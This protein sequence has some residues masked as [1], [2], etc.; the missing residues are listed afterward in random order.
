MRLSRR[1][2][3]IASFVKSDMVLGD[4]GSDHGFLPYDLLRR[5]AISRAYACDNKEGPYQNLRRTF[6][7]TDL[8]I[9]IAKKNG[10]EDLPSYV[11]TLLIAGMGGDLI[12]RILSE[13][14]KYLAQID[15][16]I[17]SPHHHAETVREFLSRSGFMIVDE[18][19]VFDEKFYT[20]ISCKRGESKL[21]EKDI[22]FGPVLRK[23][24]DETFRRYWMQRLDEISALLSLRDLSSS[25]REALERQKKWIGEELE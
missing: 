8:P 9:E 19:I 5:G 16:M 6:A 3:Y 24:K 23:R 15:R 22:F 11:N 12:V 2:E 1:L 13:G 17:L 4:I 20:V 18:G 25:R 10:L 7:G 21:S 14:A